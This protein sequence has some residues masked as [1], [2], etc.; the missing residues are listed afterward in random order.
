M[1][2]VEKLRIHISY[3]VLLVAELR[4]LLADI[5]RAYNRMYSFL[6][7]TH[8]VRIRER[9]R[10]ASIHTGNSVDIVLS[11]SQEIILGLALLIHLINKERHQFWETQKVKWDAKLAETKFRKQADGEEERR[12]QAGVRA[13]ESHLMKAI[14][15]LRKVGDQAAGSPHILSIEITIVPDNEDLVVKPGRRSIRLDED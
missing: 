14:D 9:M 6:R 7:E 15:H 5:E 3:D 11:G 12:I 2:E 1:A 8:R 13:E 10:I 4:S